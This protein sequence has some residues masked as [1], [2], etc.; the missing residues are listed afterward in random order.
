MTQGWVSVGPIPVKPAVKKT[1]EH[2]SS[3]LFFLSH[4]TLQVL[5]KKTEKNLEGGGGGGGV[6][7][8]I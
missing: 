7:K 5:W 3:F 6:I 4:V 2:G 1:M 8:K